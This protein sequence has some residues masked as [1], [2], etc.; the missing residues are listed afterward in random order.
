MSLFLAM[1]PDS[2]ILLASLKEAF[3]DLDYINGYLEIMVASRG[4]AL[5]PLAVA[6]HVASAAVRSACPLVTLTPGE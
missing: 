4:P 6:L 1:M 2:E 5:R 3:C